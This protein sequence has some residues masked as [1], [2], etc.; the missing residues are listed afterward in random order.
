MDSITAFERLH[1]GAKI[2]REI[3]P[4]GNYI[5]KG[6][7]YDIAVY[8]NFTENGISD[9]FLWSPNTEDLIATDWTDLSE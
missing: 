7:N 2:N 1:K 9:N 5:S 6:N 8:Y 3:W 4:L